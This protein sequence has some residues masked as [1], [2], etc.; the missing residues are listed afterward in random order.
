MIEVK[1]V[2][3]GVAAALAQIASRMGHMKPVMEVIAGILANQT[4][5]NFAQQSGPLGK[6]PAIKRGRDA[7]ILQ[8]SG[9]LKNSITTAAGDD[10]ATIG[11][12][13]IYAAIHQFGGDINMPARSQQA[14]FKQDKQGNVGNRFV[15]K[16]QSNFAQWHSRGEHKITMPARPFLPV[17]G[18]KLQAG[19]EAS[20]VAQIQRFLVGKSP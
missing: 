4:A 5:E 1:I 20:I 11:T 7:K 8:D 6:W 17:S 13:V 15:R 3:D 2:D 14:Y 16:S 12:N 9:R 19:L 10:F 18:G